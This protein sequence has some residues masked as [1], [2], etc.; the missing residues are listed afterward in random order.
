MATNVR[1]LNVRQVVSD[2]NLDKWVAYY[3]RPK[4]R[5]KSPDK[6]MPERSQETAPDPGA[7]CADKIGDSL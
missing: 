4:N 1:K 5:P 6:M 3:R 2:S 7:K